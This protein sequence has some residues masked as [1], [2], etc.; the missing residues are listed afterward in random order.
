MSDEDKKELAKARMAVERLLKIRMRSYHEL[1]DKLNIKGFSPE[2]IT[3]V[4]NQYQTLGLV[5]DRLFAKSWIASRLRRSFGKRRIVFELIKKGV[6]K[7]II[8]NELNDA[9]KDINEQDTVS[10]LAVHRARKYKGL[11]DKKI[12]ERVYG[13]LKRRGFDHAAIMKAIREL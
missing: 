1:V 8:E 10:E 3:A 12:Q 11:D 9:H 5:D 4:I 7:E 13:Y 6:D 2:V